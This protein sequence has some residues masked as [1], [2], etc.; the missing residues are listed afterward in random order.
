MMENRYPITK[1]NRTLLTQR[2][3][4]CFLLDYHYIAVKISYHL[5]QHKV[6]MPYTYFASPNTNP[7]SVDSKGPSKHPATTIGIYAVVSEIGS[8]WMKPKK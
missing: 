7:I 6:L 3:V 5:I 4:K 8:I 2:L 1:P